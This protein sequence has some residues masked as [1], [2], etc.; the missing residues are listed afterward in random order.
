[1]EG[2]EPALPMAG[3]SLDSSARGRRL[4]NLSQPRGGAREKP[5]AV[6]VG[7]LLPFA[8]YYISGVH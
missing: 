6:D 1:V 7:A 8:I 2:A 4:A 3:L 5:A